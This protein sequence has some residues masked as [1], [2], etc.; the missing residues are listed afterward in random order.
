M[1][2]SLKTTLEIYYKINTTFALIIKT[3][4]LRQVLKVSRHLFISIV[5]NILMIIMKTRDCL[6]KLIRLSRI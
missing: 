4:Y 5:M 6:R 2:N 3:K 1:K